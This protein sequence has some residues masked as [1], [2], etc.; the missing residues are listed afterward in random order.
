MVGAIARAKDTVLTLHGAALSAGASGYLAHLP[1][2]FE[3]RVG[4]AVRRGLNAAYGAWG[5]GAVA[6]A[7]GAPKM[8]LDVDPLSRQLHYLTDNGAY[9]PGR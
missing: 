6:A 8:T 3:T 7:G 1:L 4:I 5:A 9:T 2:G